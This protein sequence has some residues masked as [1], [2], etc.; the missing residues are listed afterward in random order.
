MQ[1][2]LTK[3]SSIFIIF[4]F[5]DHFCPLL[6]RIYTVIKVY[7]KQ[8]YIRNVRHMIKSLCIAIIFFGFTLSHHKHLIL[9]HPQG[10]LKFQI[11]ICSSL[12]S[13]SAEKTFTKRFPGHRFSDEN[14]QIW[15]VTFYWVHFSTKNY[16]KVRFKTTENPLSIL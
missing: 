5:F 15:A 7:T 2:N 1:S 10:R 3:A 6:L 14:G 9:D 11:L 12:W 8:N 16:L 13:C 4:P